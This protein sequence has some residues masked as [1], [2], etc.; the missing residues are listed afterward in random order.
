MLNKK[1]GIIIIAILLIGLIF[2]IVLVQ[3]TTQTKQRASEISN[4]NTGA[5]VSDS[6]NEDGTMGPS[7][8]KGNYSNSLKSSE[9]G[10]LTF[11][12]TDPVQGPQ[13]PKRIPTVTGSAQNPKVST[14]SSV[15]QGTQTVKA[16]ILV[17]KKVEIHLARSANKNDTWEVIDMPLPISV[18]LVQLIGGGVVNLGLTKLAAGQYTEVRLYIQSGAATL[19]D[20]SIVNLDINGKDNIVRIVQNFTIEANKNTNLIM[21]FDAMHSVVYTGKQYLLKPVVA[22]LIVNN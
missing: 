18:D 16:L 3:Q 19:E 2:A 9:L 6:K 10:T 4:V 22:K 15:K 17:V 20:D 7:S 13:L 11:S 8:A 14:N 21:D 1:T 5:E 12:I